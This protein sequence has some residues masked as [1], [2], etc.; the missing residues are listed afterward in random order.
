[1]LLQNMSTEEM[2][3]VTKLNNLDDMFIADQFSSPS[4]CTL[5]EKEIEVVKY[6]SGFIRK[7]VQTKCN[8][9]YEQLGNDERSD[10]IL[11]KEYYRNSLN[12]ASNNL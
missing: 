1:M 12:S 2:H 9:C 7:K 8:N 10:F 11:R 5:N 3:S 4:D 6:I